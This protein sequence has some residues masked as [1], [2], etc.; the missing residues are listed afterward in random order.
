MSTIDRT[1][2][3][4]AR[5][6]GSLLRRGGLL[7]ALVVV[8]ALAGLAVKGWRIYG[9][10][11]ALRGDVRALESLARGAPDRAALTALGPQLATTRADAAALRAEAAPL[12]PLTRYLGWLP[13][14]GGDVAAAQP[15]L[16][17]AAGASAAADDAFAA[18]APLL[19]ADSAPDGAQLARQIL[20]ARPQI[21]SANAAIGRAV[22]A[23]D[24]VPIDMLSPS[25]QGQVRRAGELLPLMRDGLALALVAPNVLD[26]LRALDPYSRALP[27]RDALAT[28]GPLLGKTRVDL[29]ALERAAAPLL[30]LTR[31][32]GASSAYG[33][34]LSAAGTLLDLAVNL[35]VAAD[36]TVQA[37]VPL[38]APADDAQPINQSLAVRLAIGRPNLQRAEAALARVSDDW[39]RLPI[40]QLSPPL[41]AGLRRVEALLPAA[42]DGVSIGLALPGLLGAD[43]RRDYLL[44]AQNSD[45]LRAT[46]G[47]I[48]GAGVVSLDQ[49]R[50]VD[51]AI[52]DSSAVDNL[53][54]NP[55]PDPP[56]PL[57]RYMNSELW[58]FRDTNW[59]PDFPTSARAALD[60]YRLGQGRALQNVVAIDQSLIRALL[61]LTGPLDVEGMPYPVSADNVLQELRTPYGLPFDTGREEFK[62]RLFRALLAKLE[63][64][65]AKIDLLALLRTLRRSLDERHLQLYVQDPAAQALFAR[66]GWDGAVQPGDADFLMVVDSNVGYNK[67][68]PNVREQ[69]TYTLDLADPSAPAA[70]LAVGYRHSVQRSDACIQWDTGQGVH[71]STVAYDEWLARCYY[72]YLRVLVPRGTELTDAAPQ[73]VP[74]EWM[75]SGVGDDGTVE[76]SEG[77]A[78]TSAIATF[79]VVPHGESRETSFEYKLPAAVLARGERGW[80]YR[81]KIQ[82]QAGTDAIPFTINLR[83]PPGAALVAADP[84]P[85]QRDGDM[86]SF[87]GALE[88]DSMLDVTFRSSP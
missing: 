82:K 46:G 63:T 59:S 64:G 10:A 47:F 41:R 9:R 79:L 29:V 60:L 43:G 74:G 14:Y 2:G 65:G 17:A 57:L 12:L 39:R 66:H 50:L 15:L 78:G 28:L 61:G 16:D 40:E 49:G 86:L 35:S 30:P 34:D 42:N 81:L 85:D 24:H 21:E 53:A 1:S 51:F 27:S 26:D 69:I 6:R 4:G 37:L 87:S 71:E 84:A 56:A 62:R 25:L 77:D 54:A 73:R 22:T 83:L 52:G 70:T 33:A 44:I 55:Y 8:V 76:L 5:P 7:I 68:N 88:A 32:L 20:A 75:D 13:R 31:Q 36:E 58:L 67:A 38:L 45:E 18:L 3:A 72:D 19:A 80:R 11:Q 23:W 48:S